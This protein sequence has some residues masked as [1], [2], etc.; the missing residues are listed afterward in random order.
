[1]LGHNGAGKTTALSV[2]IHQLDPLFP[3]ARVAIRL[4]VLSLQL[5]TCLHLQYTDLFYIPLLCGVL[6][7]APRPRRV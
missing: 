6:A 1:V 4:Q 7:C 2:C 5:V 3:R